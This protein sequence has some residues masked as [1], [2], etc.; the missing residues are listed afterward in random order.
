MAIHSRILHNGRIRDAS[1]AEL[2]AGQVGLLAGLGVFTTLR[3]R[4]GALFAWERHWARMSR[5]AKL[6]NLDMPPDRDELERGLLDLIE[7]N[8]RPSCTLRLVLV[9]NGGSAWQGPL[10]GATDVIALT[11]DSVPWGETVK[12]GIQADAR[13]AANEFAGA[14]ILSWAQNLTWLERAHQ[15]GFDEVVLLNERGCVAECTSANIFAAFGETVAT[16]PLSD[17]CLPGITREILLEIASRD[18][19]AI[20]ERSLAPEDLWAADEVFIT[21]TTRGLLPVSEVAGRRLNSRPGVRMRLASSFG[22]F[23][24]REIAQR[25]LTEVPA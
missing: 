1:G 5:D 16:P 17:G 13:F 4:D 11:A 20:T 15:Q 23:V 8:G 25:R 24:D 14:K 12:L 3:V 9:R 19:I 21:S 7:V 22:D 18:G 10:A 2:S 6:I